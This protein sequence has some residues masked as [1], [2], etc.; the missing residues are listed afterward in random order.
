MSSAGPSLLYVF[1][2]PNASPHDHFTRNTIIYNKLN[3][4]KRLTSPRLQRNII[5]AEQ[6][7]H[8][9]LNKVSTKTLQIFVFFLFSPLTY[10]RQTQLFGS[11]RRGNFMLSFGDFVTCSLN[12]FGI[13]TCVTSK[14]KETEIEYFCS[15]V[16]GW[17]RE[18]VPTTSV[19]PIKLAN[20]QRAFYYH[21]AADAWI[22]GRVISDLVPAEALREHNEACYKV[23]FPNRTE[24]WLPPHKLQVRWNRPPTNPTDYLGGKANVTPYW[25]EGRAEFLDQIYK[26]RAAFG[27]LTALASASVALMPHQHRTVRK[28]LRDP[29]QRYLLADEVGLGKTIEAAIIIRQYVLDAPNS[30]R[31]LVVVPPHLTDQWRRELITRASLE[32][33][34]DESI[35]VLAFDDPTLLEEIANCPGMLVVDEAH[36]PATGAWETDS[37]LASLY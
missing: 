2:N 1:S 21:E 35:H 37:P 30:H 10:R 16:T 15:P 19:T 22:V 33:Y 13:G 6:Q 14:G 8:P 27:G 17:V 26:Q 31:V 4:S 29:I 34:L 3:F 20:Q 7:R 18:T 12:D 11:K 23:A 5:Y 24:A 9:E 32:I 28:I 36:Q 25:H